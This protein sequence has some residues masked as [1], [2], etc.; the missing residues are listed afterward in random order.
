[1]KAVQFSRNGGVEVLEH[2]DSPLPALSPGKVLI[3]NHFAGVNFIDTYFRSGLYPSPSL[4][5][6]LGREGAGEVVS[7]HE[8]VPA[9]PL[10][11]PGTRVVFMAGVDTASYAGYSAIPADKLIPVP[12]GVGTDVAVAS[13]LQ[14]LTALTLIQE[15]GAVQAGQWTYVHAAAGGVGGLLVQMLKATGAKVIASASTDEKLALAKQHGA[16]WTIRSDEDFVA[17]VKEI[18][19]GHGVDVIFDGIGKSTFDAD[20]DMIAVKGR[21]VSFGNAVSIVPFCLTDSPCMS[22]CKQCMK[23]VII[24]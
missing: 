17:K 9:G 5:M 14:G 4:P 6:V 10:T 13:Y 18:T 23:W 12:D 21:L 7:A 19:G 15:A 1:M 11:T 20:L 3:R 16:E 22:I 8:S 24:C 2:V